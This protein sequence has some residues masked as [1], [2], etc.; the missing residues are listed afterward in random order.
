MVNFSEES[1]QNR[2]NLEIFESESA[3]SNMIT[4]SIFSSTFDTSLTLEIGDFNT[5]QLH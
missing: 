3:A 1:V 4:R 5:L 2:Q